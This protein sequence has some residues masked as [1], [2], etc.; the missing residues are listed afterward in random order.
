MPATVPTLTPE[1][2]NRLTG[3][4][5][6]NQ[7]LDVLVTESAGW[8]HPWQVSVQWRPDPDGDGPGRWGAMI[9]PGFVNGLEASVTIAGD[10]A[11]RSSLD[12]LFP[13]AIAAPPPEFD[14]Y[15]TER[16]LLPLTSWREL[17]PAAAPSGAS[18]N[19]DGTVTL[20]YEAVP[21]FFKTLGVG[22][23]PTAEQIASGITLAE[24]ARRLVALDLVLY[25]DR[26]A[27]RSEWEFSS[28][29]AEGTIGRF[30]IV[31][32]PAPK[33]PRPYIRTVPKF[34]DTVRAD[35]LARLSGGWSDEPRDELHLAEIFLVS[36]PGAPSTAEIDASWIPYARH[37]LFWNLSHA[38][39]IA[40]PPA[41]QIQT[42]QTG[43]AGGTGD[44]LIGFLLAQVNDPL[45]AIM[46]FL[47]TS[48]IGGRF[49]TV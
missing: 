2:W 17:G 47:S 12:R 41:Q 27:S 32:S 34:A 11:P 25:Q 44:P 9:E 4:L 10:N 5:A 38:T 39:N 8:R 24:D 20:A 45:S 29:P 1:S 23:A 40:R 49:W 7:V 46:Q 14:A 33:D 37:H 6:R 19:E 18:A 22:D 21:A 3:D 42:F 26:P 35:V 16:P 48:Q 31:N 36:P 13:D 28:T 15:L 30:S 43:L